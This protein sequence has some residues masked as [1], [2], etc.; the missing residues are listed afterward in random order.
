M[1]IKNDFQP[2]I[3]KVIGRAKENK[4]L[5]I[6]KKEKYLLKSECKIIRNMLYSCFIECKNQ[7]NEKQKHFF[8]IVLIYLL[9]SKLKDLCRERIRKKKVL[10]T[11]MHSVVFIQRRFRSY[12]S[13]LFKSIKF[14]L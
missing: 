13:K 7:H 9:M 5:E 3:Q 12:L 2:H 1:K 14:K 10:E 8:N 4:R 6:E 11:F